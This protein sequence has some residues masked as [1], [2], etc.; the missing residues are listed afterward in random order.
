MRHTLILG[1]VLCLGLALLAGE[2]AP[3]APPKPGQAP[4]QSE[5][6]RDLFYQTNTSGE[7]QRAGLRVKL[8]QK[9]ADCDFIQVSPQTVFTAGDSV[10]FGVESNNNGFLYIVLRGSSGRST[11]LFPHPQINDGKNAIRR[12]A[13]LVIPGKRW[14]DF[15]A[16]A[17]TEEIAVIFSKK[18]LDLIPLLVPPGDVAPQAPAD[19]S[20]EADVLSVFQGES[21]D[22]VF[23]PSPTS[24]ATPAVDSGAI[25]DPVYAVS[26]APSGQKNGYCVLKLRLRHQ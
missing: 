10:R 13:E 5:K 22:L 23:T 24:T 25:Y 16:N 9:M 26:A 7:S 12:G 6:A 3:T 15:D 21:R 8:Y 4:P 2:I 1:T 11:L 20:V 14:F 18:K 19:G 17:G